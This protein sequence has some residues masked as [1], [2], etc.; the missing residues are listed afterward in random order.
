MGA[1]Q[2][3]DDIVDVVR[4]RQKENNPNIRPIILEFRSEYAKWT[5]M[6]MK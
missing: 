2:S 6:R 1:G 4:L 3:C 5:V